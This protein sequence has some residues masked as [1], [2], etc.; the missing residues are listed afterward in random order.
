MEPN[1]FWLLQAV[2]LEAGSLLA[3]SVQSLQPVN[4]QLCLVRLCVSSSALPTPLPQS[5]SGF[6]PMCHSFLA[7][8][9]APCFPS[10]HVDPGKLYSL[11]IIF[12]FTLLKSPKVSEESKPSAFLLEQKSVHPVKTSFQTDPLR[13]PSSGAKVFEEL[14]L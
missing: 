1:I 6:H 5:C 7:T 14:M 11:G 9:Q 4:T 13:T 8:D 2:C 3:S 12:L 10:H